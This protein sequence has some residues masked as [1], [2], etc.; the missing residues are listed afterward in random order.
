MKAFHPNCGQDGCNLLGSRRLS[1]RAAKGFGPE[2]VPKPQKGG[3]GKGGKVKR[4]K[5]E[6]IARAVD[7]KDVQAAHVPLSQQELRERA[8]RPRH[9]PPA[10]AGPSTTSGTATPQKA[11][12]GSY[13]Y[14]KVR[15]WGPG[16]PADLGSLEV[17]SFAP[18]DDPADDDKPFADVLARRLE[19]L[20][21]QG[22]LT[23]ADGGDGSDVVP[24]QQWSFSERAY[25]Q[26]L[27][28]LLGVH[29]VLEQALSEGTVVHGPEHYGDMGDGRGVWT[30]LEL[31]SPRE[32]LARAEEIHKDMNNIAKS[33]QCEG[34]HQVP[35]SEPAR[36]YAGYL[37]DCGRA[38]VGPSSQTSMQLLLSGYL[39]MPT[40]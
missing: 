17:E 12:E 23:R 27:T 30:A 18:G 39:P 10:A 22:M 35:Y 29:H 25:V 13:D 11:S 8:K 20:Q 2:P 19:W 15:G 33:L 16:Q 24:F 5:V 14:V 36:S 40:V 3:K 7:R 21:A 9:A 1:V 4:L 32:G 6:D 37:A 38:M 34:C 31:L 28:D 26:Y